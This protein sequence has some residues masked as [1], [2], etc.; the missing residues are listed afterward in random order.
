MPPLDRNISQQ[1]FDEVFNLVVELGIEN[2]WVQQLEAAD[3]YVPDFE[4]KGHPFVF[5]I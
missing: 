2:G 3:Y 5:E 4:R 1:E